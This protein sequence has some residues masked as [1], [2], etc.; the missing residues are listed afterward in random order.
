MTTMAFG[1]GKPSPG[2]KQLRES[3]DDK[4]VP[5]SI[6]YLLKTVVIIFLQKHNPYLLVSAEFKR[7]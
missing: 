5:V 4:N 6:I 2:Q 7:S 3:N 1:L